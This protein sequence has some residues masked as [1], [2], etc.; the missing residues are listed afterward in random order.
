MT[1]QQSNSFTVVVGTYTQSMPHVEGKG[2]GIHLLNFDTASGQLS[3][4]TVQAAVNPTYLTVSADRSRVYAV[5]EVTAKVGAGVSTYALD[6]ARGTL[7]LLHDT[8]T[9]GSWPCHVSVDETL[10]LLLVSNYLSGEVLALRLDAQRV[11][12]GAPA[13]LVGQG[14][15]PNAERQEGPHAHCA[16][17]SPDRRHVYIA[18]LGADRVTRHPLA[19]DTGLPRQEPDLILPAAPG[20]GP[21]HLAFG[22]AGQCLLVNYELSSTLRMYRLDAAG[23]ASL[24]SEISSLPAGFGG[25]SYASAIRLHPSGRTVYVG[26]RGHDSVFAARVDEAAGTLTPL[27][28][29]PSGGAA[30]RDLAVSPDGRYLLAAS[31]NDG[32]IRVFSI[33]P[34]TGELEFTGHDYPVRHAV[35]VQFA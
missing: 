34:Q 25:V 19:A 18:D 20:A 5:R 22:R 33:D 9:P 11:P 32:F 16:L 26:N 10:S 6:T 17:V 12:M 3:P 27:G 21:R 14:S 35:C 28:H 23:A 4:I 1:D 2:E 30:P 24:S 13:V 8:P 31:Q 29:W 7:T 15:G